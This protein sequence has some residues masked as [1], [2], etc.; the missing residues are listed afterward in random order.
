MAPRGVPQGRPMGGRRG[1]ALD[2]H[3]CHP[4]HRTPKP[5]KARR[6]S[7]QPVDLRPNGRREHQVRRI[8]AKFAEFGLHCLERPGSW[9]TA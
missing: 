6:L 7:L 4:E 3:L 2:D 1:E 9:E 8:P 5:A